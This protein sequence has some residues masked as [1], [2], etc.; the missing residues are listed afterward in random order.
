MPHEADHTPSRVLVESTLRRI[1]QLTFDEAFGALAE[2]DPLELQARAVRALE[3]DARWAPAQVVARRAARSLA[4]ALCT[5]GESV[6]RGAQE[7]EHW[8]EG[9]VARAAKD[10]SSPWRS[11]EAFDTE[12]WRLHAERVAAR[13]GVDAQHGLRALDAFD[14]LPHGVRALILRALT[15][16]EERRAK[17]LPAE[18]WARFD[19]AWRGLVR[20]VLRGDG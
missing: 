20:A 16:I 3:A 11:S 10:A 4:L 9:H 5:H 12:Q 18:D 14:R 1:A 2:G 19:A 8:V 13:L 15:M 6:P 7:A 17:E